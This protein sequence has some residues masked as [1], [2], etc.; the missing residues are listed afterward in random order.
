MDRRAARGA[1][2]VVLEQNLREFLSKRPPKNLARMTLGRMATTAGRRNLLKG[3]L[4]GR[5]IE[6]VQIRNKAVHE[7]VEPTREETEFVLKDLPLGGYDL[8]VVDQVPILGDVHEHNRRY[9]ETKRD[10][11]GHLLG[12]FDEKGS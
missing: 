3:D 11:M 4:G 6:A 7:V 12:E 8:E 1:A 5:L 10:K 2:A 9:I